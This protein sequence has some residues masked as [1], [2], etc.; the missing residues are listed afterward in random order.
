[1]CMTT[2]FVETGTILDRI[3]ART[4]TD[5]ADRKRATPVASLERM[6]RDRQAP[7]GLR[8]ALVRP[9]LSVIAEIK[10]ASPSKGRFPV[11]IEPANLAAEYLTGG[12]AALSVLTDAPF[13]QGSLDDLSDAA[14][15]AHLSSL[16]APVLRKDF[17][18]EEYQIHEALAYGADA[19]LLIVAALDQPTL[20][21]L[22]ASAKHSG[23]DALVEVHDEGEMERALAAGAG[24]IGIN[25]RD[26]RT[27][28]VDLAVTELLA[29]LAPPDA[30][31]V[32]ESGIHT[33]TDA[34]RLAAAGVD[35]ILVGESLIVATDRAGAVA[36]LT[37][38]PVRNR[39][40]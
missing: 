4:A 35:A 20:A 19:V 36:A 2:T 9:G 10:R 3:L 26:L 27:F 1:M 12:A 32:G 7:V 24:V 23:L 34:A 11:E 37:G 38:A 40:G 6:A 21:S 25:N 31:L 17:V 30:V 13:F 39:R 28:D 22:L 18:V 15:V 33:A 8:S 5:V 29:P 16:P 14:T